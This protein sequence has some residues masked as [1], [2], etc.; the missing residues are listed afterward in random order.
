MKKLKNPTILLIAG[1]HGNEP[2]GTKTLYELINKIKNKEIKLIRGTLIIIPKA[3]K[4]GYYLNSRF[5]PYK[6]FNNDLNRNYIC[7]NLKCKDNISSKI[8]KLVNKS[9]FIIDFHEGWGYHKI[10]K[11]SLGST[12]TTTNTKISKFIG[13][14][15]VNKLNK[16]YKK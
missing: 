11:N 8:I 9:D 2:A 13:K 6:F 4:C 16:N 10:N 15:I 7:N 3:N 1:T 5:L 14:T 12:I